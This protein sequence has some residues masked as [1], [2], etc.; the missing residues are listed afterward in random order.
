L[1][2]REKSLKDAVENKKVRWEEYRVPRD[3]VEDK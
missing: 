3:L 2:K 1:S